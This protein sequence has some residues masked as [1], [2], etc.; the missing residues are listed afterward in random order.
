MNKPLKDFDV[1]HKVSNE[2]FQCFCHEKNFTHLVG[3]ENG[4]VVAYMYVNYNLNEPIDVHGEM[5][6]INNLL[7]EFDLVN[8]WRRIKYFEVK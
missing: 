4:Y 2:Y 3:S 1:I 5:R 8:L 7:N 6:C